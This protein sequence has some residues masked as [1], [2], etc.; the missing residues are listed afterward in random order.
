VISLGCSLLDL[1][2]LYFL[3][4]GIYGIWCTLFKVGDVC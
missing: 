4:H 1:V 2:K 3:T